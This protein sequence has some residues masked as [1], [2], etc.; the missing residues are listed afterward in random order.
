MVPSERQSTL[1]P[2]ARS[3][4]G[5]LHL[6]DSFAHWQ[7]RDLVRELVELSRGDLEFR[8]GVFV[9]FFETRSNRND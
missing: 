6:Q 3:L 7:A 9:L 5:K 2:L 8:C 4:F 1:D